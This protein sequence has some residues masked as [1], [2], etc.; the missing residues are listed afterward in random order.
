MRILPAICAAGV[1]LAAS[2]CAEDARSLIETNVVAFEAAFERGDSAALADF[3]GE[4]GVVMPPGAAPVTGSNAIAA[5]WQSVMDSGIARADLE[6]VDVV[7]AGKKTLVERGTFVMY[8]AAGQ[9]VGEGKYL[10][11]WEKQDGA[12]KLIRDIWSDGR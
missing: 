6:I 9:S 1:V 2:A 3:Y 7:K 5:F 12:W 4:G 10:V 11:V 8:D